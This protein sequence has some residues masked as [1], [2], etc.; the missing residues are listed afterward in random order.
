MITKEFD[1]LR[2][3]QKKKIGM[4][5][6]WETYLN[7]QFNNGV[8][9]LCVVDSQEIG[10]DSAT[11]IAKKSIRTYKVSVPILNATNWKFKV[12]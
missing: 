9:F 8:A 12:N 3:N 6:S 10:L 4:L 11:L 2:A 7:E 1:Y 5:G